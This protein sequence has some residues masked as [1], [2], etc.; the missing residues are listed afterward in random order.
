M[1]IWFITGASRGFG[2]EIA[3]EALERGDSVVATARSMNDLETRFPEA[4]DRL[5]LLALDI[6]DTESAAHAAKAVLDR[7]GRIDVLV[8]NAGRGLLA[9]IEEASDDEIRSVFEVNV[10]GLLNITR[11]FLPTFRHQR[12][13]LIINMSSV[14]G[15][16]SRPGWGVYA[17]TKFAVEAISEGLGKELAPLGVQVTAIEPGAFRTNFLDGSSLVAASNVIPDYAETAGA[18]RKWAASTNNEQ[19]GDPK[20]AA[21]VIVDLAQ[22]ERVPQRLQLGRDSFAAVEEKAALVTRE[23]GEWREVSISTAVDRD[24]ASEQ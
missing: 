10:F 14:A 22:S 6:T 7:F 5:L 24:D 12:A 23:Q 15:F 17:S 18:T 11:A 1:T 13:G 19:D 4:S 20:K 8:N 16:V 9:A 3:R 21:R 2:F